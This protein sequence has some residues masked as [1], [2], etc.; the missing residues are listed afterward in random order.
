MK[1]IATLLCL[2]VLVCAQALS[3]GS[4]VRLSPAISTKAIASVV[5]TIGST[6]I[7]ATAKPF[8]SVVAGQ[9]VYGP[10]IAANTTVVSKDAIDSTVVLSNAITSG[11]TKTIEFGYYVHTAY[12]TGEWLGLP[13]QVYDTG[14]GGTSFL[15]SASI[16][17]ESDLLGA[18]DIVFF[19]A[20]SDTLGLDSAT[21]NVP[22]SQAPKVLGVVS[23]STVTD[24]GGARTMQADAINMAVPRN[25][26]WARLVA[27]S[28]MASFLVL[29]PFTLRLGFVQ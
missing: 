26:L 25:K 20:Y 21:V 5:C 27:K 11:G 10:G 16:A 15:V 6:T 18:V 4:V 3:Q 2:G 24:L 13:F 12:A 29:Q 28:S 23:L 17:D 8:A 22:L 14:E 19:S 7:S 9:S 1:R